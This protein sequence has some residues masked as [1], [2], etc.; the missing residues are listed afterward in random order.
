MVRLLPRISEAINNTTKMMNNTLA[1]PA[2]ADAIP[3]NPKIPATMANKKN[4]KVHPNI[5]ITPSFFSCVMA[6]Y[7]ITKLLDSETCSH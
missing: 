2:R 3:K 4:V 7:T 1:I 5:T 6:W